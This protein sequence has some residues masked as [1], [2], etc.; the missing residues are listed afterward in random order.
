MRGVEGIEPDVYITD[1]TAGGC[2]DLFNALYEL[3]Y[4]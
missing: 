2:S 1:R 3:Y 4:R